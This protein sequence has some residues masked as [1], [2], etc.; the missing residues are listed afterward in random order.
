[1]SHAQHTTALQQNVF[2]TGIQRL[3]VTSKGWIGFPLRKALQ[4]V[5][6][7]LH[8]HYLSVF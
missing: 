7:K 8:S 5:S 2:L 6:R 3:L 1:M 4:K